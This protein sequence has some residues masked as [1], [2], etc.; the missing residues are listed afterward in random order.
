MK[1][2]GLA[3]A[4][5]KL[6]PIKRKLRSTALKSWSRCRRLW[7]FES[8]CGLKDADKYAFKVGTALHGVA[9]RYIGMQ[10]NSWEALFPPGWDRGLHEED[11]PMIR[12]MAEGA[13]TLGI[14]KA[15]P[16]LQVEYPMSYLIGRDLRD[17]RGM[18][19]LAET[20]SVDDGKGDRT[21]SE[22]VRM[23]DGSPLPA[24][25]DRLPLYASFIDVLDL[26]GNPPEVLDHKS[27]RARRWALTPE[28]LAKDLQ[29]LSYAVVP[30]ALRP[31]VD[32]VKL[33]HAVFLKDEDAPEPIY[34]VKA[35]TTPAV[36]A[37]MWEGVIQAAEDMEFLRHAAPR[38][39]EPGQPEE[40]ARNFKKVRCAI[41]EGPARV[42]DACEAYG[43]CPYKD[44]CF[45]RATVQQV[46]RRL[47]TPSMMGILD[48][49]GV[50]AT[51]RAY[52]L[53]TQPKNAAGHVHKTGLIFPLT[54]S[55]TPTNASPG[56]PKEFPMAFGRPA[57]TPAPAPIIKPGVEA[58]VRDPGNAAVQYRCRVGEITDGAT[59]LS[60]FPRADTAPDYA[61]LHIDY[62]CDGVPVDQLA[63]SPWPG[64]VVTDYRDALI[65]DNR[66]APDWVDASGGSW[67][68]GVLQVAK[69]AAASAAD[70]PLARPPSD[71][72]FGL[73]GAPKPPAAPAA[74]AAPASKVQ[75]MAQ[76]TQ[77][78]AAENQA[79]AAAIPAATFAPAE[80]DILVVKQNDHSFW[81][82][83]SGKQATV[84]IVSAGEQGPILSVD[85][86][87]VEYND[88]AAG[89]F[90]LVTVQAV[91][92][93]PEQYQAGISA[94]VGQL[95][96]LK[97]SSGQSFNCV[98][99]AADAAGITALGDKL[100]VAWADVVSCSPMSVADVP[101]M[102]VAKLKRL[103]RKQQAAAAEALA[104]TS[105]ATAPT[106]GAPAAPPAPPAA[107]A[108][109]PA[110]PAG[111]QPVAPG[112]ALTMA[113]DMVNAALTGGKVT[114]KVLEGLKPLLETA[115]VNQ[116]DE[117]A[118]SMTAV[119]PLFSKSEIMERLGAASAALNQAASMLDR[120]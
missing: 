42:K 94:L 107:P 7:W 26:P 74:P 59:T 81:G 40:R 73:A 116:K 111:T 76:Q 120:V 82:P 17:K 69:P 52:G 47:D 113:L 88:V 15:R 58:Y 30:F 13:V 84:L 34:E 109:P 87:G 72:K 62:Q 93:T 46:T 45:G 99:E 63:V 96:A 102:P 114:R 119:P 67:V 29:V 41:D 37:A 83:L 10:V 108:A 16:G 89:R 112:M 75:A 77:R 1:A 44:V 11:V 117:L 78:V 20:F 60:F 118:E 31:E 97:L 25:W 22:P 85:I 24:G 91:A 38:V 110:P 71:G 23:I 14:W 53:V 68:N 106:A 3:P 9:E 51:K 4:V 43:G 35:E 6:V 98:L 19:L 105:T 90:E 95:V 101:G 33:R 80:G 104:G 50:T 5:A 12:R 32:L 28:K 79:A 92:V 61:K 103:T 36:V 65:A 56:F 21:Q 18:P 86:D 115:L 64:A 27:S 39:D 49:K 57:P 70:K 66:P 2:L 48:Q 8:V 100:K 54:P 55:T